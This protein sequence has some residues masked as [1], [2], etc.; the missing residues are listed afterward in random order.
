MKRKLFVV[1]LIPLLLFSCTSSRKISFFRSDN[2][3]AVRDNKTYPTQIKSQ[4]VRFQP[5]DILSILINVPGENVAAIDFNL[6]L[7]PVESED[8]GYVNQGVGRQAYL[9][10]K[11]GEIDFPVLGTIKVSNFTQGELEAYLKKRLSTY[12]KVEPIVTVRL[13]NFHISVLGEVNRP[14][15]YNVTSDHINV[16]EALAL[17]GDMTLYGKR[18]QV[19]VV[20]QLPEGVRIVELN[21]HST[22][23]L[24]SPYFYLQQNDIVLV[25]ANSARARSADVGSQTGILISVGSMLLTLVNLILVIVR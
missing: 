21:I 9:V 5:D 10:D 17:A 4:I 2:Q 3:S 24:S 12:L 23:M 25:E 19:R 22:A 1:S 15:R 7:Q 6:P 18:D 11:Q 20:R 14:G 16:I 13:S 8:I